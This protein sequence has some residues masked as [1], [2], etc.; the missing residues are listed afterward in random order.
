MVF[1]TSFLTHSSLVNLSGGLNKLY[2]C[3]WFQASGVFGGF[4]GAA[5]WRKYTNTHL[6]T[7]CFVY[8]W[9]VSYSFPLQPPRHN[10]C[11]L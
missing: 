2:F 6:L 10:G 1:P 11:L 7:L 8:D 5:F 3:S 4:G 9:D